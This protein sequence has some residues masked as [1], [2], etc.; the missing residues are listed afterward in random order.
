VVV[1]DEGA[2]V[3]SSPV[4]RMPFLIPTPYGDLTTAFEICYTFHEIEKLPKQRGVVVTMPKNWQTRDKKLKQRKDFRK[5]NRKSVRNI[6]RI[7]SQKAQ[8]V[9]KKFAREIKES[10]Q[11]VKII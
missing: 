3:Q 2:L 11:C 5:D 10:E 8:D 4:S 1:L 7:L 9:K 6:Q